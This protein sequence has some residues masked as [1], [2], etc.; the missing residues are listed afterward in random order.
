MNTIPLV[1]LVGL[2]A[3]VVDYDKYPGLTPEKLT[4]GLEANRQEL[5]EEGVEAHWCFVDRGETAAAELEQ[6]LRAHD[7]D[8]ALIGAGVRADLELTLLFESLVNVIRAVA[9]GAA[10][11]FNSN[12]FDTAEA[13]RRV[14]SSA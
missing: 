9:P 6:A 8:C 1:L 10:L 14:T 2:R 4:Q 13:V 11:A 12:P 7:Y 5:A 3:D